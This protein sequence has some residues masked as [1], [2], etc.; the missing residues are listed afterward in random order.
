VIKKFSCKNQAAAGFQQFLVSSEISILHPKLS[1]LFK[2]INDLISKMMDVDDKILY[3]EAF[4]IIDISFKS[5]IHLLL[6]E[7]LDDDL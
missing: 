6:P 4:Q 5:G 2:K 7:L 3:S 1:F